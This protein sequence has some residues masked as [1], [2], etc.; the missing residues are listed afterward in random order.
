MELFQ[1]DTAYHVSGALNIGGDLR[2]EPGACI[3]MARTTN[4][5]AYLYDA[6]SRLTNVSDGTYSATYSYLANLPLVS[7]ITLTSNTVTRMTMMKKYDLLNRLLSISS[8]P[9][10]SGEPPVSFAYEYNG[11]NQRTKVTHTD[12]LRNSLGPLLYRMLSRLNDYGIACAW[13]RSGE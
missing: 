11:A 1:S 5:R 8:Q 13:E 10:A 9:S 7:Q 3:K 12:E 6:A 4:S 2:A